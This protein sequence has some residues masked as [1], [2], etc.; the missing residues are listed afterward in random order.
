[1]TTS[2]SLTSSCSN[3]SSNS[4][5]VI[6]LISDWLIIIYTTYYMYMY[7][8]L[9]AQLTHFFLLSFKCPSVF[10]QV[11]IKQTNIKQMCIMDAELLMFTNNEFSGFR[12]IG[13][14]VKRVSRLNGPLCQKQT[15]DNVLTI[16]CL[17]GSST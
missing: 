9:S 3:S 17:I 13:P 5:F 16:L 10:D 8:K 12:L 4:I 7:S 1:M 6:P 14:P 2:S 11:N 15:Y